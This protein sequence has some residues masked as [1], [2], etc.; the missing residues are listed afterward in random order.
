MHSIPAVHQGL[1]GN[2]LNCPE[3]HDLQK[4]P[5]PTLCSSLILAESLTFPSLACASGSHKNWETQC[6][7]LIME[8]PP[9]YT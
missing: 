6:Y 7:G 3:W 8:T 2:P 9:P 1:A 5:H 4:L